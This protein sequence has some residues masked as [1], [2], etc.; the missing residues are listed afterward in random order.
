MWRLYVDG[1]RPAVTIRSVAQETGWS[2]GTIQHYFPTQD[3]LLL[4]AMREMI[5]SVASRI[6]RIDFTEPTPEKVVAAILEMI[7]L[8]DQQQAEARIWFDLLA[9]RTSSSDLNRKATEIDEVVRHAIHEV[10]GLLSAIG[11]VHK[12]RDSIIEIARLHALV[13]GLALHRLADPPSDSVETIHRLI[14]LHVGELATKP[15][16]L[17]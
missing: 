14:E 15:S 5:I 1:G 8:D 7:P 10:Y 12:E 16:Y 13:D 4:F 17:T 2:V 6:G 9:R 11:M 3:D